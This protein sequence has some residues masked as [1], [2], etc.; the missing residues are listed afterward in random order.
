M[1]KYKERHLSYLSS[2]KY[3][4]RVLSRGLPG[5]RDWTHVSFTKVTFRVHTNFNCIGAFYFKVKETDKGTKVDLVSTAPSH[6]R[7]LDRSSNV[8]KFL[9]PNFNTQLCHS[10]RVGALA[11]FSRGFLSLLAV[12]ATFYNSISVLFN[13]FFYFAQLT[14]FPV[15]LFICL[16]FD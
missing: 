11:L 14:N 1:S 16:N 9:I 7:L 10:R 3:C 8:I 12:R 4:L 15:H 6:L 5:K 2:A 13:Y